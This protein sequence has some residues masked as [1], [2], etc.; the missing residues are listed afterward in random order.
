MMMLEPGNDVGNVVAWKD[1]AKPQGISEEDFLLKTESYAD[2]RYQSGKYTL[3]NRTVDV[4]R[5]ITLYSSE[6]VFP[7]SYA[8]GPRQFWAANSKCF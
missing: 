2:F 1:F 8:I 3:G 6:L 7:I 5:A 4:C